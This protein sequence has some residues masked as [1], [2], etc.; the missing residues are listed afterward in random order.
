MR[1]IGSL[2]DTDFRQR[3]L[4]NLAYADDEIIVKNKEQIDKVMKRLE[5]NAKEIGLQIN[6][7]VYMK[8]GRNGGGN[9]G[10][11]KVNG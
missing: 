10:T 3:G 7:T 5:E 6:L 11:T 2:V 4:Q 9:S 1:K 8:V